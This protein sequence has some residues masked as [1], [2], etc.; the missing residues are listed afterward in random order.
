MAFSESPAITVKEVDASGV[1]PNVS[2][3]TGG[4]V[5]KFRWGPLE[6][7]TTVSNEADLAE[8]FGTP[9][10]TH[11]VDFHSAAYFLKYTNS[12]QNV[13]V[14]D[15][16]CVN[17]F[18]HDSAANYS[19]GG[20]GTKVQ[21]KD[22]DNFDN[23]IAT[24]NTNKHTFL[25]RWPGT[26]GNSLKVSLCTQHSGGT[27][28]TNW[29]YNSSFDA[30]PGT[31][32]HATG[33][34]A[35]NDE[36]HV[37]VIDSDGAISGTRGTVLETYPFVSLASDAKNTDG[38]TNNI[39]DVIN[40]SSE[41]VWM[42][43]Y[44][45]LLGSV[46]TTS[47]TAATAGKDYQ[48]SGDGLAIDYAFDSGQDGSILNSHYLSGFDKLED[49]DNIQ[50]D[51]L[52]CPDRSVQSDNVTIVN[53]ITGIAQSTR[54]DCVAVAS[55]ARS[56]VVGASTPVTSS[57][58]NCNLYTNSS[59]LVVDNNY[60]K[61]YDKYNDQFIFIPAAS[62]T[63]GIMA[64]TDA[65]AAAWF[66]PG[67]P[68]RGQYLGVTNIAYSPNKAER[69]TLYRAGINPIANIPGQGLLLFG[70][71]TKLNRPSAFDRINVRRL[72]LVIER[73]IALAARNVMFE[74]NDEFTR[75]EFTG[76]V[77]PF[78]REVKGRR[79]ISDFRVICDETNN[80]SS[81]IDR[82]EF[83]ATILVKPA[84]SINFVTLNF[85]AVRSGVDFTEVAGTV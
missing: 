22:N 32:V 6:L 75:A 12:L 64:A 49:K 8:K 30:A 36:V 19:G 26:L 28:F 31:S 58:T 1:V 38:S 40:R 57:V 18:A 53:D 13:R 82:N 15:S 25:S 77:E 35:S 3:S 80:T 17:A 42:A 55:P 62:S 60:L 78:L 47:G 5:G 37:A 84:R 63:A 67:G 41:Y 24:L 2:S 16:N 48:L 7:A 27:A 81:V 85:V 44:N 56:N 66:S 23:Q 14:G 10:A 20:S 50:V 11:S 4:F 68:R 79:G 45:G 21:I 52:I 73:A 69:D 70:D 65:N 72:F 39:K 29:T 9:D 74:F 76:I 59:Y 83:V 51:F 54:K 33:A 61:V 43:G 46:S 71:K 34:G